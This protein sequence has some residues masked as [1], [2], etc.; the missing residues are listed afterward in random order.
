M[1]TPWWKWVQYALEAAIVVAFVPFALYPSLVTLL[2]VGTLPAACAL[3]VATAFPG[4]FTGRPK[5]TRYAHASAMTCAGT[6]VAV[7]GWIALGSRPS[8]IHL[9]PA[10]YRGLITIIYGCPSGRPPK[11][12]GRARVYEVPESGVL[13]VPDEFD[14]KTPRVRLVGAGTAS[15]ELPWVDAR[16]TSVAAFRLRAATWGRGA[17]PGPA[18]TQYLIGDHVQWDDEEH[19]FQ[20]SQRDADAMGA[21]QCRR[22]PPN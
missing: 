3:L 1:V 10:N 17:D 5:L 12:E 9:L 7:A 2:V 6:A 21:P 19:L 11:Y 18:A 22:S 15:R 4:W 13:L 16:P 14:G 8:P 20:R